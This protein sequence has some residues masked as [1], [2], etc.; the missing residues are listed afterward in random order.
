MTR[1]VWATAHRKGH[2][3]R[4]LLLFVCLLS[5][6]GKSVYSVAAAGL[7]PTFSRALCKK[8]SEDQQLSRTPA[9]DRDYRDIQ[10]RG[11]NNYWILGLSVRRQSLLDYPDHNP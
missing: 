7:N 8:L 11:L 4:K 6:S 3:R 2:R 5:L 10:C 1:S 9:L